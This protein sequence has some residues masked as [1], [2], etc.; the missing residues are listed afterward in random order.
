MQ[1]LPLVLAPYRDVLQRTGEDSGA[2]YRCRFKKV[3]REKTH[4]GLKET[5]M[6]Q[7]ATQISTYVSKENYLG[8]SSSIRRILVYRSMQI[9]SNPNWIAIEHEK[10]CVDELSKE[11]IGKK[12]KKWMKTMGRGGA[13]PQFILEMQTVDGLESTKSE[14]T[15]CMDSSQYRAGRNTSMR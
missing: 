8:N 7:K 13:L 14:R 11:I 12:R 5:K 6:V 4:L 1:A 3:S 15:N 10:W 2:K 9:C